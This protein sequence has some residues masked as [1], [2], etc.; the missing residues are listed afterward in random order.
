MLNQ[1]TAV[2]GQQY[3]KWVVY[4]LLESAAEQC[5]LNGARLSVDPDDDHGDQGTSAAAAEGSVPI[6][7]IVRLL[8]C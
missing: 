7:D 5:H 6:E 3:S 1:S 8:Y 4:C 2:Y